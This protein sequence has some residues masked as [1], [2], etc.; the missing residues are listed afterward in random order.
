MSILFIF[1][2]F[3]FSMH[4]RDPAQFLVV[5]GIP[6][7]TSPIWFTEKIHLKGVRKARYGS[8]SLSHSFW[9]DSSYSIFLFHDKS[10]SFLESIICVVTI[11]KS[12]DN[13]LGEVFP[14]VNTLETFWRLK[15]FATRGRAPNSKLILLNSDSI[16]YWCLW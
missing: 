1:L 12:E 13:I 14:F 15:D 11:E 16:N 8:K 10:F 6:S 2:Q 7:E 5:V 3:L 4:Y 9:N